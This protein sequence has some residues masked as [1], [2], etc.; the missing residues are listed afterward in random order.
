MDDSGATGLEQTG[1]ASKLPRGSK[2]NAL[3]CPAF[4]DCLAIGMVDSAR[5]ICG[6]I[7]RSDDLSFTATSETSLVNAWLAAVIASGAALL[8][9]ARRPS[10]VVCK[11]NDVTGSGEN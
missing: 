6:T 5:V 9:M 3:F 8:R 10:C 4:P 7:D 1:Q 11:R 2:P